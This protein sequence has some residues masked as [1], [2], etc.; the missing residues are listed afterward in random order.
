VADLPIGEPVFWVS[1]PDTFKVF[2]V[3]YDLV[4]NQLG[5]SF[6]YESGGSADTTVQAA[7]ADRLYA[8]IRENFPDYS[9]VFSTYSLLALDPTDPQKVVRRTYPTSGNRR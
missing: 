2:Q 8:Y 3:S 4:P 7:Y 6:R 5:V 9:E 1:S